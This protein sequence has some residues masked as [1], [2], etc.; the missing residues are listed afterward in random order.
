MSTRQRCSTHTPVQSWIWTRS[1][2]LWMHSSRPT[3]NG[4]P[5]SCLDKRRR[6]DGTERTQEI[7]K[8]G[9]THGLARVNDLRRSFRSKIRDR[10]LPGRI[11]AGIPDSLAPELLQLLNSEFWNVASGT[12][13]RFRGVAE[14][15]RG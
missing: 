3:V 8:S 10:H 5:A 4:F 13:S 2:N 6:A 9:A 7:E 14:R 15:D 11:S 1:G 12:P